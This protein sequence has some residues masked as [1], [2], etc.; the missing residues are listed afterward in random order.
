MR[1]PG[2][3]PQGGVIVST[4]EAAVLSR[5]DPGHL[6]EF[7]LAG[8]PI[9][10]FQAQTVSARTRDG[11]RSS[12]TRVYVRDAEPVTAELVLSGLGAAEFTVL[13]PTGE[14]VAGI[15]VRLWTRDCLDPCGCIAR[16]SDAQGRVR[17]ENQ[18]VGAAPGK[19]ITAGFDVADATAL[20]TE[21]GG[22]GSG[23]LLR[24]HGGGGGDGAQ[25]RRIV[26]S[27]RGD[28]ADLPRLRAVGAHRRC[29]DFVLPTRR[30]CGSAR[31]VIQITIVSSRRETS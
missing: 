3:A 12:L 20:I 15:P 30:P 8:V 2:G 29:A 25:P 21:D 4:R 27:R 24:R 31:D 14:A 16:M 22:V 7:E 9:L 6:G 17:F 1:L 11:L 23:V 13:S 19:A 18:P 26:R 28:R 5:S 10:P